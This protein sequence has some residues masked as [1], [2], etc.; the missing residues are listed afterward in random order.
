MCADLAQDDGMLGAFTS[1]QHHLQLPDH[2]T[3][4]Q[5]LPGPAQ[6]APHQVHGLATHVG[7]HATEA[8]TALL[9]SLRAC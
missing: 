8:M 7:R 6:A 3:G 4:A 5:L 2:A 9:S 1:P